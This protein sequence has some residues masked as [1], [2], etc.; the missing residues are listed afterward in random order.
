[1]KCLLAFLFVAATASALF[2]QD[3]TKEGPTPPPL[4][5]LYRDFIFSGQNVVLEHPL[6][7]GKW[8]VTLNMGDAKS[9]RKG[10]QV[11]AEG[12]SVGQ[13]IDSTIGQFSFVD[14]FGS[15]DTPTFFEVDVAD[16]SLTLEFGVGPQ[17][18]SSWALNCMSVERVSTT[19]DDGELL[20]N[21]F[22]Y[23]FGTTRSPV[24][25]GFER[26]SEADSG[27]FSFSAKVKSTD[28]K[29]ITNQFA[30]LFSEHDFP[31][32]GKRYGE[33]VFRYRVYAPP[34]RENEASYPLVVWLHGHDDSG[35][36]NQKQL[37]WL[38][39]FLFTPE[40]LEKHKFYLLAVQCPPDD[41][42]W[43]HRKSDN[44]DEPLEDMGDICHLICKKTIQEYP[45]DTDRV[46][47]VGISSGGAG[48]WNI[49]A[50]F[51]HLFAAIIPLASRGG[52][53]SV[54]SDPHSV[55][56]WAF[57]NNHDRMCP[58]DD[59]RRYVDM[60][61]AAGGNVHFTG[62]DDPGHIAR[63]FEHPELEVANWMFAK[64]RGDWAWWLPP[65]SQPSKWP[66]QSTFDACKAAIANHWPWA[67]YPTFALACA[68]L[69]RRRVSKAKERNQNSIAAA[70]S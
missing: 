2:S 28:K 15:S 33:R 65:G 61:S 25:P 53:E 38:R 7:N 34:A 67:K 18:T 58:I 17:A 56:V 54:I 40:L 5:D 48:A 36:E 42:V 14:R 49:G 27:P 69:I 20:P 35:D 32:S 16:G 1:M 51:S 45:I 37:R 8:R 3:S 12:K 23:D 13:D 62:L 19:G 68:W 44:L 43:T 60:V 31:H 70:E 39:N 4:N 30:E 10:M 6:A 63:A 47:L 26:I 64:K 24:Q 29:I 21:V 59:A 22:R 57:T 9:V 11:K 55:P 46:Y 41:P 66:I 50:R 52:D